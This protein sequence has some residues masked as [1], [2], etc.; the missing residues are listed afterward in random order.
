MKSNKI[1]YL[2]NFLKSNTKNF[3]FFCFFYIEKKNLFLKKYLKLL[4]LNFKLIRIK[5]NIIKFFFPYNLWKHQLYLFFFEKFDENIL[6]FF[7]EINII[8]IKYYNR[9][10]LFNHFLS[11]KNNILEINSLNNYN[12]FFF[13]RKENYNYF[14]YFFHN[15]CFNFLFFFCKLINLVYYFILKFQLI[16]FFL[17]KKG[18][19][20]YFYLKH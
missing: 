14:N 17:L 7:K 19:H 12:F 15:Y 11:L 18:L 13:T 1:I 16:F 8:Y 3:P 4:P 6:K 20:S 2:R 5:K 9:F 10:Y